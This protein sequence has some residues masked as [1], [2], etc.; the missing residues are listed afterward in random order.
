MVINALVVLFDEV[1]IR[2]LNESISDVS[3]EPEYLDVYL[4]QI[5]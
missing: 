4:K 3:P 5:F 2:N 1:T